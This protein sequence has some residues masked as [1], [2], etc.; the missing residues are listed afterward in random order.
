LWLTEFVGDFEHMTT[1]RVVSEMEKRFKGDALLWVKQQYAMNHLTVMLKADGIDTAESVLTAVSA[2]DPT[3][4]TGVI[5]AYANPKCAADENFPAVALLPP[6]GPPPPAP[7]L[8]GGLYTLTAHHSG[9]CLDVADARGDNGADVQQWDCTNGNNQKWNLV[10]KGGDVYT[11][12]ALHSGR[13]LDVAGARNDNGA[14]VLQWDCHGKDNQAWRITKE[15]DG[16]YRLTARHSGKCLDVAGAE[17]K[18]GANVFQWDCHSGNNQKWKISATSSA[19]P[20]PA[21][22]PLAEGLYTL[23]AR[24]SGKCLDVAGASGKSGANVLQWDCHGKDNQKWRLVSRGGDFYALMASHSGRC[25]DVSGASGNNGANVLQW[26]CHGKDN[27]AWRITKE[28]DGSYRLTARHSGKCL[29]VSGASGKN[30]ANV[31]QWDCHGKDN[32]K[33]SIKKIN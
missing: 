4:M 3:G 13:C 8:A 31:L 25:L 14:D 27:Q 26:D 12:A 20:P 28:G 24:H 7:P 15:G 30:G 5:D 22:P 21:T 32:Q 29:D 10:S 18:K 2:F 16:S 11:L 19:A 23:T 9:K 1:K 6:Y 17:L 33:W